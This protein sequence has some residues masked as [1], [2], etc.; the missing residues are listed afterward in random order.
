MAKK[1]AGAARLGGQMMDLALY[2]PAVIA[3]RMPLLMAE[4]MGGGIGTEG[5]SAGNEKV[6]AL[7]EAMMA[8]Q[9]S[10]AISAS[11]FW[12]EAMSGRTPSLFDGSAGMR[13]A[14]AALAPARRRVKGNFRRLTK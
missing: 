14:S 13:A 9:W 6:A 10:M 7:G 3:L 8:A 4:A 1:T 11:R 12:L 2:S 5:R